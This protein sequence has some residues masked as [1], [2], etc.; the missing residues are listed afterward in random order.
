MDY[1]ECLIKLAQLQREAHDALLEKQWQV[2]K[3][4]AQQIA[5]EGRLLYTSIRLYEERGW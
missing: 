4:L 2:A 1:S 3:D 5:A